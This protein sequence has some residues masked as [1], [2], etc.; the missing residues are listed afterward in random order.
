[1]TKELNK[2]FVLLIKYCS[3]ILKIANQLRVM[4]CINLNKNKNIIFSVLLLN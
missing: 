3:F 4:A 1:M 2:L